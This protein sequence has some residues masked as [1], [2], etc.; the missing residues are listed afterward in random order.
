MKPNLAI[1][2]GNAM[3]KKGMISKGA[4]DKGYDDKESD[5]EG[6]DQ[7]LEEIMTDFLKAVDDKDTK[8]MSD[9]F[10]EAFMCCESQPHEESDEE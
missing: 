9:L 4:E 1:I 10:K 7:Y 3:A 2:V 5:D 8:A 6:H